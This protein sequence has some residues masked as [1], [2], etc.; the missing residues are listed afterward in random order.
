MWSNETHP[1]AFPPGGHF[2]PLVGCSHNKYYYMWAPGMMASDGVKYVAE[3]GNSSK[4]EME[5]NMAKMNSKTV[6]ELIKYN[7]GPI[8]GTQHVM[9]INVKVTQD[10]PLVS[11][12]SMIAPSPD[13]FTGTMN[14]NL[15][16]S[17]TGMWRDSLEDTN[18]APWD[19]GTEDGA[20][21]STNNS[22]TM[23][24][25]NITIISKGSN[26][27]FKNV[28]GQSI[29]TLGKLMFQRINKPAMPKCT[30]EQKYK[31]TFKTMWKQETHPNGFPAAKAHF[32]TLVVATHTYNYQMWGKEMMMASPGV[33]EVAETGATSTLYDEIKKYMKPNFVYKPYKG[34]GD[35]KAVDE[36]SMYIMVKDM[37]S[38]VSLISMIAP[39]PDWFVG[40]DSYDLC[41]NDGKW[42]NT[43]MEMNLL[44]WDAGTDSGTKFTSD[45]METK[46]RDFIRRI[47]PASDEELKDDASK[48]FAKVTFMKYEEEPVP[49]SAQSSSAGVFTLLAIAFLATLRLM[50]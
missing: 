17:S 13:W 11:L 4:L 39:S 45:D 28:P 33:Q 15:C 18:L 50:Y 26:T 25:G 42:K 35:P 34:E 36:V 23:P 29:A 30:G 48:P 14:E 41:G 19:A 12:V 7:G 37:Y 49:D 10:Y 6:W 38:M 5:I 24:K 21:F 8:N 47:T 3:M 20:M 9:N 40:V 43:G 44:P 1:N 46:P 2:S 32:S 22:Q 16:N 27:P 31:V